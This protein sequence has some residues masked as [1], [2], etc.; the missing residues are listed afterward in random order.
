MRMWMV[1]TRWLCKKHLLGEHGE[2]HKHR[3]TFEKKHRK[4]KYIANN[5]IEP[6]SMETRH[7]ELVAEMELRGYNH[8]SPFS[9][10]D[11][12]YLPKEH[13]EYQVDRQAALDDLIS[14]CPECRKRYTA[15]KNPKKVLDF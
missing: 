1:N 10:P 7:T 12:S 4:D 8:N 13:N 9:Q 3:W 15:W 14:R 5:C 11:V 6:M 2:L